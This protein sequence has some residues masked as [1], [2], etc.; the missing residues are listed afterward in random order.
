[1][2]RIVAIVAA[3]LGCFWV[4]PVAAQ[5]SGRTC[6]YDLECGVGEACGDTGICVARG[7]LASN[8]DA[9]ADDCGADRRCRIDRLKRRNQATRH[10]RTLQEERNVERMLDDAHKQRLAEYPRLKNPLTLALRVSRLGGI[11]AHVG[12]TFLGRIQ[13]NLE[14]AY[15]PSLY[16]W[17]PGT[18][19]SPGINGNLQEWWIRA[20]AAYFLLESWFSPYVSAGFQVGLGKFDNYSFDFDF[21]DFGNQTQSIFHAGEFGGGFDMQF[22]FGLHTRLGVVYRPLI[23][24]QARTGPGQYDPQSRQGLAD[25]YKR[26]AA[27]DVIWLLGWAI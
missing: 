8:G 26:G 2:N 7:A 4:S 9:A 13:P 10:A 15:S 17:T 1:M 16:V 27:V 19:T 12:Y 11:G 18:G 24:N 5:P 6:Q 21:V 3:L 23:Y 22:K 25:W 14:L 20:G